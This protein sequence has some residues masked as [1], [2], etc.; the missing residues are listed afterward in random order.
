MVVDTERLPDPPGTGAQQ[1]QVLEA[2]AFAHARQSVRRLQRADQ[3]PGAVPGLAA[4][5][6]QA[7]MDAVGAVDVGVARGAE[8]RG[9]ARP[10]ATEA[11]G[12]RLGAVVGL[13]LDDAPAHA[14]DQQRDADQPARHLVRRAFEADLSAP[15]R[16]RVTL[17]A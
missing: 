9:I 5:E 8:Q 16:D 10:L 14:V 17:N 3:H 2:A 4:D 7:P 15:P 11:V 1:P 13:G 6:V 12:G